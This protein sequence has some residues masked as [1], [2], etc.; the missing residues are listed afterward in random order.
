MPKDS[1]PFTCPGCG[2]KYRLV[3]I[4]APIAVVPDC[5]VACR[6]CGSPLPGREGE[7]FLKYFLV[8]RP[9]GAKRRTASAPIVAMPPVVVPP[10]A[11]PPVAVPPVA[12]LS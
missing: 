1:S 9:R 4:E 3:K 5:E 12:Q 2:A 10:V 6:S 11:V 7:F 8:E